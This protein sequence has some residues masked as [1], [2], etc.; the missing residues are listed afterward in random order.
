MTFYLT[1][2]AERDVID[3]YLYSVGTSGQRKPVPTP[4]SWIDFRLH[5]DQPYL[6]GIRFEIDPPVRVHT[7]GI[8][9]I[10]Y[11]VQ[12]DESVLIVR[13]RH[14]SED[15]S[16]DY[17][18]EDDYWL[19]ATHP[20]A[21]Q[22]HASRTKRVRTGLTDRELEDALKYETGTSCYGQME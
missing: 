2:E 10:I 18:Q 13:V 17:Q 1:R 11:S 5:A 8:H 3:I 14:G 20:C 12:S 16:N 7:C 9:I 6:A 21:F 4:T 15:W 22:L 19:S